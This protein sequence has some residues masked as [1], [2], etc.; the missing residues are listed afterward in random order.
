MKIKQ[1]R[2][3]RNYTQQQLAKQL[4]VERSTISMWETEKSRPSCLMLAKMSRLFEVSVDVI[5][6]KEE[7]DRFSEA[8]PVFQ[9]YLTLTVQSQLIVEGVIDGLL[10][11]EVKI[12]KAL[13]KEQRDS[14]PPRLIPLY[15]TAAA[16][17]YAAPDFGVDFDYI[18]VQGSV[19]PG[20]DYAVHIQGD[21]ME[22]YIL[23]GSVVYVNRDPMAVGDVGI[24]CVD[25]EMF[26]KQY[27][28]DDAGTVYLFSLNRER[29]DADL[30]LTPSGNR[31][32]VWYGRVILDRR[33]ELPRLG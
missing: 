26:C 15:A 7:P 4:G 20:A 32:L 5:L 23:D 16:A 17:G 2:K 19:P 24:F 13:E 31:S 14:L 10:D 6:G 22:P 9:K 33:P 21:S 27:Y 25:G 3:E 29:A 12:Q 18:P 8:N 1:L 11:Y 28:K 30:V